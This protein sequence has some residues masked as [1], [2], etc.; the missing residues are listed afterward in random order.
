MKNLVFLLAGVAFIGLS[1]CN[2]N[3][4]IEDLQNELDELRDDLTVAENEH[5]AILD[6]ISSLIESNAVSDVNAT[7]MSVSI[8]LFEMIARVPQSSDMFINLSEIIYSDYTELLPFTNPT[9]LVRGQAL[10]ELFEGIARQPE[11]FDKLDAAATQFVGPFDFAQMS[12]N[13][14]LV[15]GRARGIAIAKLF[16]GIARQPEAFDKLKTAAT[17]YLGVYDPAVF[18]D[19]TIEV[20]R[21]QAFGALIESLARQ[22]EAESRLNEICIQFLDFSISNDTTH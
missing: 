8:S 1:S 15:D 12:N 17:T 10:G 18:S 11:A 16:E 14:A 9:I 22:P 21:A 3:D 19:E 4:D 7:K 6:S 5:V 13:D 20:A 2:Y